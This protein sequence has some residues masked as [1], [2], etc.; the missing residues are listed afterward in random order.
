MHDLVI[1]NG[2]VVIPG[3]GVVSC[4]IGIADGKV[5]GLGRWTLSQRSRRSTPAATTSSP[6][7]STPTSTSATSSRSRRS[8]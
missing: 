6:A 7:S 3:V 1:Q 5:T 4:D 2:R 8:A